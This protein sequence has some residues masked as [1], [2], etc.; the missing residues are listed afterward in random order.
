MKGRGFLKYNFN[1]VIDRSNNNAA[2]V[3]EA[4]LHFGTNDVIPLWIADMDFATLPEV[5]TAIKNRA[6]QGIFGYTNRPDEYFA[7]YAAW[8]KKRNGWNADPNLMAFAPGVIP[9]MITLV[10]QL[11]KPGD[12]ILIQPPVYHP[13]TD[14]VVNFDRC[15]V[16]NELVKDDTGMYRVDLADFE[17]KAKSGVKFF[18]LCNPHN[19][20]GRCWTKEELT[21]MAEICRKYNIMIISD[22]IHSDLILFGHKH[23]V[24]A[25]LSKEISDITITCIAPSK[26]FNLA[27]LQSST[28]VFPNADMKERY[29]KEIQRN[30]M[31]RNNCFSLVA[32]MA[33][34]TYGEEWV[35]E[36]KR[37]LEENM[38]YVKN[39]LDSE[40]PQIKAYLPQAT[41]L[42]WL[43]CSELGFKG[44]ALQEFLVKKAGL[45]LNDGESFGPGG[46]GYAR[47][48]VACPRATL[49]RA[50]QQLKKAVASL[51]K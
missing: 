2:K 31:A 40:I 7:A 19:P 14:V 44:K 17:E 13:F 22:E 50:L 24:L 49:E 8:Q 26:T 33:A 12:K 1:T 10:K 32:A 34:Y 38:R 30:D 29:V 20:V 48:N 37:Y 42:M 41:Y 18:I 5:V 39:F 3:L 4:K 6:D 27:G 43:D 16:T 25:S 51:D 21:A 45:G 35:E 23:T 11:T 36:L 28:I 15:L 47:M 9:G 46:E